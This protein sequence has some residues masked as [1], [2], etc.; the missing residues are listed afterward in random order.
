MAI[1]KINAP[2][3]TPAAFLSPVLDWLAA[4]LTT[5]EMP[6]RVVG[7][8][9]KKGALFN[10]GG[11]LFVAD[12][13]TS[14]TGVASPYIRITPSGS[15]ATAAF[16]SSLTGVSWNAS[17]NGYYDGSG[18]LYI[19]DELRALAAGAITTLYTTRNAGTSSEIA[20]SVQGYDPATGLFVGKDPSLKALQQIP[21]IQKT[22]APLEVWTPEAGTYEVITPY[23]EITVRQYLDVGKTTWAYGYLPRFGT[24]TTDGFGMYIISG[25]GVILHYRKIA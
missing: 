22:L 20:H 6:L 13:D 25:S 5:A 7:S 14:I 2:G 19:F 10:I 16:V 4:L 1:V 21:W 17:Y 23:E 15:S 12:A 24:F 11:S 3:S 18:N 9:I 8:V